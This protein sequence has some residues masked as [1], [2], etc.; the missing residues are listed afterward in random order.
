LH[1]CGL[2][3]LWYNKETTETTNDREIGGKMRKNHIRSIIPIFVLL[4]FIFSFNSV[5]AATSDVSEN[6]KK[7]DVNVAVGFDDNYKIGFSTP[8]K[9]TVKNKYKDING[10]VEIRVPSTPGKYMSFVKPISLQKDAEKVI[11]INIPVAGNRPQYPLIIYNGKNKVYEDKIEI[12]MASNNITFFIGILSDDFDS[13]SYINKVSASTGESLLTRP[14]KLDEKNFPE[15]T[16]TLNSFD[17]IIIN[18]YDTSRLNK[19]QYEILK[20]WVSNGGTLLIGTGSK[21]NKTLK[22]F[23]DD[24][25]AGTQGAVKSISTSKIYELATN[26]DS[27]NEV[28]LDAVPLNIKKSNVLMEEEGTKLV[29]SLKKGK[30]TIGITSFDLGQAPFTNWSNNTVFAEKLI[31]A[32]NPQLTANNEDVNTNTDINM[33]RSGMGQFSEMAAPKASR[34]FFILFIYIIVLAPISYLALKKLDKR[35]LMWITVPILAIVFGIIVYI[36][37]TGTRMGEVTTNMISFL[38]FDDNGNTTATTYAGIFNTNKMKV[39]V[40]GKDEDKILPVTDYYY[41]PKLPV[42]NESMEAK[43]FSDSGAVEYRNSSLLETQTLQVQEAEKKLGKIETDFSIKNGDITGS[44]KNSTKLDL[45]DCLLIV[46]GGYYKIDSITSGQS[47]KL[48]NMSKMTFSGDFH[49]VIRDTFFS[50]SYS[51]KMTGRDIKLRMDRM[52]EGEILQTMFMNKNELEGINFIAFSKTQIHNPL[53]ING[54]EARKNERNVI[55][56]K[57]NPILQKGDIME[58]P[59][60]FVPFSISNASTLGYDMYGRVFNGNGFAQLVYQIDNNMRVDEIGFNL[61]DLKINSTVNSSSYSILNID[62]NLYEPMN[63]EEIKGN[64]LKKY[65][66]KDNKIVVKLEANGNSLGLPQMSAKG[67]KK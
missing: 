22:I 31:M 58:Y 20:Q 54:K 17:I 1:G 11:T 44:I 65:L 14:I 48:D 52:Q 28:E 12:G 67:R 39:K 45:R 21:Y 9:I 57:L 32:V 51:G 27:R 18:D 13:L 30:G 56:L 8:V 38:N 6:P 55:Y 33:A 29:Q 41:D 2:T 15:D 23:T 24:F 59:L 25:I 26:G 16:F 40:T 50:Y 35:E 42:D 5:N 10:E 43:V 63:S 46:P 7:L 60:G 3:S 64:D 34:F 36:S 4:L 37:G 61:S 62:K 19:T 53:I 49:Q 66:S 47:I